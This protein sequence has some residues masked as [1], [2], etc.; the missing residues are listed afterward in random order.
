MCMYKLALS[1]ELV[2]Q[3]RKTFADEAV[4]AIWLQKQVEML[5]I[6]RNKNQQ[7]IRQNAR[8][9]IADMRNISEQ[10]GN[11]DMSLEDIN[12]EIKQAREARRITL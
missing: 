3:T 2:Q 9:A 1:D 11:A 6:E 5:M 12:R 4:M 10:K 8:A 7:A